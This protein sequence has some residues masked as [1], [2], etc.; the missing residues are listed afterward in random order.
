MPARERL[1]LRPIG[2]LMSL[3]RAPS[4][5]CMAACLAMQRAL[6][7]EGALAM[8]LEFSGLV[9]QHVQ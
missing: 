8:Y 4:M 1:A 6:P 3:S 5:S 9:R 7:A 2:P